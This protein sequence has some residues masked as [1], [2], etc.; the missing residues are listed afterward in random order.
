MTP[1]HLLHGV[2]A[3]L[4]V[5]YGT[6][7]GRRGRRH[8]AQLGWTLGPVDPASA[9]LQAHHVDTTRLRSQLDRIS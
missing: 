8:L 2:L 4:E 3:G 9:L 7:L 5:P 1:E 6:Q